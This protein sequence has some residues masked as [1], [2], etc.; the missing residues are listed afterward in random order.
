MLPPRH[1]SART[2]PLVDLA[3]SVLWI[4]SAAENERDF[5]LEK[6]SRQIRDQLIPLSEEVGRSHLASR[7][8]YCNCE[9]SEIRVGIPNS[10]FVRRV[11]RCPTLRTKQSARRSRSIPGPMA[12]QTNARLTGPI[13]SSVRLSLIAHARRGYVRLESGSDSSHL[14]VVPLLPQAV[15]ATESLAALRESELKGLDRG[16]C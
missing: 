3:I 7:L 4:V 9:V 6:L 10:R 16:T 2:A 11:L 12:K 5:K 1:S 14:G 13:R 8:V 15:V